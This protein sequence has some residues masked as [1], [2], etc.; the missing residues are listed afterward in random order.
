[1]NYELQQIEKLGDQ[2]SYKLQITATD[3]STNWLQIS[4]R[5]LEQ[6]KLTLDDQPAVYTVL[7]GL[8]ESATFETLE[9][10]TIF[11]IGLNSLNISYS[12]LTKVRK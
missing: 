1:M 9:Q 7:Y 12:L 10:A 4:K 8:N 3:A 11:I 2:S 5:Q 6:I